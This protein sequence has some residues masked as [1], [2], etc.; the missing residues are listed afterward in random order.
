MRPLKRDDTDG[1]RNLYSLT[2]L[3]VGKH[4]G[5]LQ[6]TVNYLKDDLFNSLRLLM[7]TTH[8]YCTIKTKYIFCD[9]NIKFY[10]IELRKTSQRNIS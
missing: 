2:E 9:L 3:M 5:A 10:S 1:R 6:L 7:L 8:N 4:N